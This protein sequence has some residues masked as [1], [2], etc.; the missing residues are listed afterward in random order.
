MVDYH[1]R[2]FLACVAYCGE[3]QE[4]GEGG[5]DAAS[6][7]ADHGRFWRGGEYVV[8]SSRDGTRLGDGIGKGVETYGSTHPNPETP[9]V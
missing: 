1:D 8:W 9:P 4:G 5:V 3:D 6:G 7:C 2:A